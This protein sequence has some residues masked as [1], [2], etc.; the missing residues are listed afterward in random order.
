M[1]TDEVR[2]VRPLG[3]RHRDDLM[4]EKPMSAYTTEVF[5]LRSHLH[6]D[7]LNEKISL[8]RY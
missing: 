2:A 4:E 1:R 7:K 6:R 3:R 8:P 5:G